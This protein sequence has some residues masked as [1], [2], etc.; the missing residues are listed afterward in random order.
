M[1]SLSVTVLPVAS[2]ETVPPTVP[3][4]AHDT[5][6][7]VTGSSLPSIVP[8]PF[9]LTVQ[10]WPDGS[11]ATLTAYGAPAARLSPNPNVPFVVTMAVEM[12][13]LSVTD[14]AGASPLTMPP[15]EAPATHDTTM[16]RT[17]SPAASIVPEPL[18]TLQSCPLG[19]DVALTEYV[20]PAA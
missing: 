13:S 2:P 11:V 12:P 19:C 3:L 15:S 8:L 18:R 10:T 5:A 4:F 17:P 1:P 6:I 16:L 14:C 7:V 20:A 9:A